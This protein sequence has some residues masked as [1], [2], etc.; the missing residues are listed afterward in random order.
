MAHRSSTVVLHEPG[1]LALHRVP[2]GLSQIDLLTLRKQR[3]QE[4]RH[5]GAL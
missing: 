1:K 3:D 2:L 4:N 5:L